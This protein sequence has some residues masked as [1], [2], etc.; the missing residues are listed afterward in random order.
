MLIFFFLS[1]FFSRWFFPGIVFFLQLRR[2][3][4]EQNLHSG[5]RWIYRK[6]LQHVFNQQLINVHR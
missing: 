4:Q 2:N 3:T 5:E 1:C 6:Q